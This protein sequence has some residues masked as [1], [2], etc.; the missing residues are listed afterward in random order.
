M[1]RP[2]LGIPDEILAHRGAS[3]D[4]PENI[5]PTV[6]LA[7]EPRA[8]SVEVD[9]HQTCGGHIV[10][11]HDRHTK[12]VSGREDRVA[13]ILCEQLRLLDAGS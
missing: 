11:I 13:E 1:L 7:S 8:D 2:T 6:L 12:R 3:F 4:A 9:I 5:L 10:A